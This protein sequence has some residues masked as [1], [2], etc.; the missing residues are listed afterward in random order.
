MSK[1]VQINPSQDLTVKASYILLALGFFFLLP[2]FL[3][4]L[5]AY[6]S[7]GKGSELEREHLQYIIHVFWQSVFY[8][9]LSIIILFFCMLTNSMWPLILIL[10]MEIHLI[11]KA[12]RGI[13]RFGEDRAPW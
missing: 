12:I 9:I 13:V 10:V 1:N 5:L 11:F 7:R 2:L 4:V 8:A 6:L 3:S